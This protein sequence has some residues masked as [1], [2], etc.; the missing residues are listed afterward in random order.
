[1]G[2]ALYC[3]AAAASGFTR[4]HPTLCLQA[5]RQHLSNLVFLLRQATATR[6]WQRVAAL[7]ATLLASDVGSGLGPS[8]LG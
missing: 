5:R 8:G 4:S 1:M 2:H 3:H 6:D 7:V